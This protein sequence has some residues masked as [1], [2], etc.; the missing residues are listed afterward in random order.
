MANIESLVPFLFLYPE[1]HF[2]FFRF[3]PSLLYRR[4]PEILFDLP[5][6][7]DPGENLPILLICN[8][9]DRFPCQLIDI[10]IVITDTNKNTNEYTFQPTDIA[11]VTHPFTTRTAVYLVSIP[12]NGR[13]GTTLYIQA[14]A[15]VQLFE[16]KIITIINDNLPTSSKVP[17]VCT[18]SGYPLPGADRCRYGDMHLHSIFSQSHVEFGPPLDIIDIFSKAYGLDFIVVTDHSYDLSCRMDNY[19]EPDKQFRRWN[20][21]KKQV[22]ENKDIKTTVLLGEEVSCCNSR[23]KVVHLGAIDIKDFVPGSLDGARKNSNKDSQLTINQTIKE[24]HRQDG[25]AFAA[26]PGSIFGILQRIFL[27]RGRWEA[28]DIGDELDG[29]QSL[30]GEYDRGWKRAKKL[31]IDKLQQRF[32]LPLFAGNDAHGDFNRYRSLSVPFLSISDTYTRYFA[33]SRTGVY[34]KISRSSDLIAG[35]KNGKTFVTTGPYCGLFMPGQ[36]N[37]SLISNNNNNLSDFSTLTVQVISTKEFG[38]INNVTV[39]GYTYGSGT[40]ERVVFKNI[41]ENTL[42]KSEYQVDISNVTGEGY[43]RVECRCRDR[44]TGRTTAA[45]TSP[46]YFVRH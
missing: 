36:E 41:S 33:Q 30:N 45:Y 38:E 28:R 44:Q 2:R 26:H 19:L 7:L 20:T 13:T 34:G 15:R 6:R 8:D 18:V 16:N 37:T 3:F 42:Y 5:R 11:T 23:G 4:Q 29:F 35:L 17:F 10:K 24:I 21:L 1:I 22:T 46:C 43:I 39:Y 32:H 27:H 31:W 40:R 25:I 14:E 9:I 12:L